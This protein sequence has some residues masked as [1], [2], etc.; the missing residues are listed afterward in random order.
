MTK[1]RLLVALGATAF[2]L[3]AAAAVRASIP[4]ERA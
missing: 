3:G 2:A 4:A 1:K